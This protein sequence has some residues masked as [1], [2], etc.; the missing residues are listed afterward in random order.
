MGGPEALERQNGLEERELEVKKIEAR[1]PM[2]VCT[3]LHMRM[4]G[5]GSGSKAKVKERKEIV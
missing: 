1:N 5:K 3:C 4:W 2:V